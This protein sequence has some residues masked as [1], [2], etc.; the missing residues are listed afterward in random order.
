[1]K[2]ATF[3]VD[4][5]PPGSQYNRFLRRNVANGDVVKCDPEAAA[6]IPWLKPPEESTIVSA[7]TLAAAAGAF[8]LT[9]LT[10]AQAEAVVEHDLTPGKVLELG[11]A[12]LQELGIAH[13]TAGALVRR[14]KDTAGNE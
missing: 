1:M 8:E 12:G 13:A 5:L 11:K 9:E 4:G 2:E 3:V 6:G 7:S 10:D 14:A